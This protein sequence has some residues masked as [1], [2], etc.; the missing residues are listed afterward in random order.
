MNCR[1]SAFDP[2]DVTGQTARHPRAPW[3]RIHQ[4]PG[5]RRTTRRVRRQ[6][7]R[8]GWRS[9]VHALPPAGPFGQRRRHPVRSCTQPS[10]TSRARLFRDPPRNAVTGRAVAQVARWRSRQGR[11]PIGGQSEPGFVVLVAELFH[12]HR[13]ADPVRLGPIEPQ[14][15]V[16]RTCRVRQP[17]SARSPYAGS[18][19][20]R[21]C[22]PNRRSRS[23]RATPAS[24]GSTAV[25]HTGSRLLLDPVRED[26]VNAEIRHPEAASLDEFPPFFAV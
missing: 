5:D 20:M 1:L 15:A 22:Q 7:C 23:G 8:E 11:G 19:V 17:R 9:R 18:A 6:P 26:V 21:R 10:S 2:Q 4:D 16:R 12:G 14:R 24:S 25:A 3:R 13:R